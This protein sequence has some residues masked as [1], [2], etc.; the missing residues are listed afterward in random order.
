MKPFTLNSIY[1]LEVFSEYKLR[2]TGENICDENVN[3]HLKVPYSVLYNNLTQFSEVLLRSMRQT[4][5]KM[6]VGLS[7]VALCLSPV[8]TLLVRSAATTPGHLLCDLKQ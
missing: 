1:S 6:P 3:S 7:T 4:L 8:L 2:R 5:V